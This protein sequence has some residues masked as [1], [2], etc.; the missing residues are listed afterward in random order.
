MIMKFETFSFHVT[1]LKYVKV[2]VD[3]ITTPQFKPDGLTPLQV[4]TILSDADTEV[5]AYMDKFD[6]LNV[7]RGELEASTAA[8]HEA[9]VD[10][11][12]CMKSCYRKNTGVLASIR[13]LTKDDRT[14][15]Q[16]LLR[17]KGLSRRWAQLP[18]PPGGGTFAVGDIT[19]AAFNLLRD[20]LDQKI[21]TYNDC[22]SQF[23]VGQVGLR[24]MD[25]EIA[26]LVTGALAQGRAIYHEGTPERAYIDA[27]PIDSST[28]PPDQAE[29]EVAESPAPG[30]VVLE[31][32]AEHATSFSVWHKGPGDAQFLEVGQSLVPGEY[33][34]TGLP[35]G[36]HAYQ[37]VGQNSRGNGPASEPTIVEVA[38]VAVA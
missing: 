36:E 15:L 23:A 24:E 9:A 8:A 7:A 6:A 14:P 26:G 20:D 19:Q 27:V 2:A 38:A 31:F 1:Q 17:V 25:E 3:H 28:Q 18:P 29:I 35:V 21:N 13:R 32:S 12:A 11:Y 33:A 34:A 37:V 5:A 10:V 4:S 22:T 16:T 30:E